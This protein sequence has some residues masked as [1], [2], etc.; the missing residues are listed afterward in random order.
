MT[1]RARLLLALLAALLVALVPVGVWVP[2]RTAQFARTRQAQALTVQ[3]ELIASGQDV[4]EASL[5]YQLSFTALQQAT[6][7]VLVTPGGSRYTDDGPHP[8]VPPGVL[9]QVRRG[10]QG[11]W[12]DVMLVAA[13]SDV[14]GLALRGQDVAGLR[15]EVQDVFVLGALGALVLAALVGVWLL[16]L[17]LAPLRRM[18]AQAEVLRADTLFG[19]VP[20]PR[21]RDEV[22]TLALGLNGLLARLEDAFARLERGEQR[23][24]HLAAD[25][26][27][28][29]RTPLAAIASSLDVLERAED[30]PATRLRLLGA[31]RREV[32]RSARL[33]NDLLVLSRLEA[34]EPLRPEALGARALL[35]QVAEGAR[36]LAPDHAFV[37]EGPD[38]PLHADRER[39]EGAVWNLVRNA[40]AQ[41]PPGG[42][43]TLR[44]GAEGGVTLSVINPGT[45]DEAFMAR[46][47]DRFVRGDGARP[48]G[49]GLGLAIVKATAEAHGGAV[50]ARN[51]GQG[52]EV[53]LRLPDSAALQLRS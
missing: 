31:V 45:L 42:T 50:L 4:S 46:M 26:S 37:V 24:R 39:L 29:L 5:L 7:G 6:W 52:V 53:G 47:F 11:R 27:H 2:A 14:L 8:R 13:G 32:R 12:G 48:G 17:G 9:A 33:V 20:E 35:E 28:E 15:R 40:V 23:A 43:I 22:R 41:T 1:L 10:G 44:V 38:T 16:R 36:H 3:L 49:S 18:A 19:R 25:A 21:P 34:G 51:T 30:D